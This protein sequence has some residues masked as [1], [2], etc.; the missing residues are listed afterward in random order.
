[1]PYHLPG[2]I[3]EVPHIMRFAQFP[4]QVGEHGGDGDEFREA[5]VTDGDQKG[6]PHGDFS[7]LR[8]LQFG[9]NSH[10]ARAANRTDSVLERHAQ[11]DLLGMGCFVGWASFSE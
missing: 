1:M 11:P 9:S 6:G 8:A 7:S 2:V 4:R 3:I 5:Q 10:I